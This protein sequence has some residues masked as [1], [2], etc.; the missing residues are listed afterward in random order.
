M[1]AIL[2]Q[3]ACILK[4][5][6]CTMFSISKSWQILPVPIRRHGR[7]DCT[8]LQYPSIHPFLTLGGR[9]GAIY[10]LWHLRLYLMGAIRVI[11]EQAVVDKT[12]TREVFP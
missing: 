9:S 6:P 2:Y 1:N 10:H 5:S 4:L 8:G 3:G 11:S 7:K 12:T